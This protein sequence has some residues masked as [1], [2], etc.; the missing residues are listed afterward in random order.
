MLTKRYRALHALFTGLAL[1]L[2]GAVSW[3]LFY[4]L[5]NHVDT[6][7][8]HCPTANT[9]YEIYRT[10]T[11]GDRLFDFL[12]LALVLVVFI[13]G[14]STWLYIVE[15]RNARR[16]AKARKELAA[17]IRKPSYAVSE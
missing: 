16:I 8:F 11:P 2:S 7:V 5:W 1:L 9:C 17:L 4:R 10:M 6:G 15:R 3:L 13:M 14:I 12:F